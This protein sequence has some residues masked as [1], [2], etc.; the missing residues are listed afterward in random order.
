MTAP[1]MPEPRGSSSEARI[2]R[3]QAREVLRQL[4]VLVRNSS[5]HEAGNEVFRE[6]MARLRTALSD[7]L[8]TEDSL[9]LECVGGDLFA[10]RIRVRLDMRNLQVYRAVV[11]VLERLGLGG[12]RFDAVP[13]AASLSQLLTVLVR[14]AP[15]G[16]DAESVNQ[17]LEAAGIEVVEALE[18]QPPVFL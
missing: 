7:V 5:L 15:R 8:G 4:A 9:A 11:E 2:L 1:R 17:A 6:P 3:R 12:L 16:M 18:P 13:D 10:N 14:R